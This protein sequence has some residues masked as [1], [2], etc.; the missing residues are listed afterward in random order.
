MAQ[1][2]IVYLER[3]YTTLEKEIAD[4][5]RHS[6][7]D[8]RA[9]DDLK[10]RKLIIADEIQHNRSVERFSKLG[11]NRAIV[12]SCFHSSIAHSEA[13]LRLLVHCY[14]HRGEWRRCAFRVS[15]L[16]PSDNPI[17]VYDHKAAISATIELFTRDEAMANLAGNSP[18]R[19]A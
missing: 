4:A 8:D 18:H 9:I 11:A 17:V 2:T 10:Y 12:G 15:S 1:T 7:T 13:A 19:P 6:P 16:D 14:G 5:L 3:R